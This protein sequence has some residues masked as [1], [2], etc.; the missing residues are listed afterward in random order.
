MDKLQIGIS[1]SQPKLRGWSQNKSAIS[2]TMYASVL[3]G[4]PFQLAAASEGAA[5]HNLSCE[6]VTAM[7]TPEVCPVPK[8]HGCFKDGLFCMR[9]QWVARGK[10]GL[11]DPR[12]TL[13]PGKRFN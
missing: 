11:L 1:H 9:K 6:S 7:V 10:K 4:E 12:Q 3:R 13:L 5:V 8:H 2:I